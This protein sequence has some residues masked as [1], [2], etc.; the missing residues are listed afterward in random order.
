M[1]PI[2]ITCQEIWKNIPE[3]EGLYQVSNFG[4]VKSL[5]RITKNKQ[6]T[7]LRKE[8]LLSL[9]ISNRGYVNVKLYNTDKNIKKTISVHRLV[10][11]CFL[12]N[13]NQYKEINHIDGDKLNNNINNLEWCSRSHNVKETYRLNLRKGTTYKGEGNNTSKLKNKDVVEIRTLYKKGVSLKEISQLFK[14]VPGTIG[15]IIKNQTWKHI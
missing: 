7:C 6:G 5:E 12:D 1:K 2:L 15:F 8:K 11:I 13:F 10:S 3:F 14:V 4:N 9:N